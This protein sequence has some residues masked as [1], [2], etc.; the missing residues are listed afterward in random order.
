M[1][2]LET[3][4]QQLRDN[5]LEQRRLMAQLNETLDV[6]HIELNTLKPK[7]QASISHFNKPLPVPDELKRLLRIKEEELCKAEITQRLFAYIQENDL[8]VTKT[9]KIKL[10]D[11][12]KKAFG[13][14][15]MTFYNIQQCINEFY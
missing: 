10:D 3:I 8:I 7:K 14:V 2:T 12:M 5:Y 15:E 4:K 9:K 11:R 6:D 13:D 1:L